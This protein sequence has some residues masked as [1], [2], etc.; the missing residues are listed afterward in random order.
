[1][2]ERG[3]VRAASMRGYGTPTNAPIRVDTTTN[4]LKINPNGSGS[5]EY[6]VPVGLQT[7]GI[8]MAWGNAAFVSGAA[9]VNTGLTTVSSFQV[10][11]LATGFATGATEI[12]DAVVSSIT[13]GSVVLQG[14][15][16]QTTT[17]SASGTGTFYWLALGS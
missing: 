8:K 2:P 7:G 12:T 9:T 13:T 3:I 10:N 4:A 6:E 15:R 11:L 5:T 17:A 14:Y 1:M 16:M